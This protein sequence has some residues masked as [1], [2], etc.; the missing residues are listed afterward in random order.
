MSSMAGG[1][2][3]GGFNKS[4]FPGINVKAM[5]REYAKDSRRRVRQAKEFIGEDELV[6]EVMD[7]LLGISVG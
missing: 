6:N 1:S 5:D 7:Y 4:P 2:V 3:A